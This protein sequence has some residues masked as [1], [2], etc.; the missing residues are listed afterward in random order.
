[1]AFRIT[2]GTPLDAEF[3]R[4]AAEQ[5]DKAFAELS[6]S[7]DR[8][9]AIHDV[10][11]RFKKLRALFRLLRSGDSNLLRAENAR[12]RDAAR[13]LSAVRDRTA[14]LESLEALEQ[15]FADDVATDAF[16]PVRAELERRR[17]AAVEAE[18]DLGETIARTLAT[19]EDSR[20]A[21]GEASF[22]KPLKR[23]PLIVAEG[24][25]HTQRAARR[26]LGEAALN[27]E[28]EAFHDLR[29]HA[30]DHA[31]HLGLLA[32]LWPDAFRVAREVAAGIGDSLG[33]DHDYAILRAEMAGDAG[34][35]GTEADRAVVLGLMDRR[36][37]ALRATSLST[38]RRLFAESPKAAAARI[39][40]L[41]RDAAKA[42]RSPEE[43]ALP[44]E[45][46]LSA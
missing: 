37:G 31:A 42:A 46:G 12:L 5:L 30:K 16:A 35:F 39:E 18:G 17:E 14:L 10:R 44:F 29:K 23:A 41:V 15:H 40:R 22:S 19:I 9:E 25:H 11:K 3:R 33:L 4:I 6:G 27:G 36:Q 45:A 34:A 2:F 7:G 13:A 8:H 28:A 32:D 20:T 43:T 38:A 21:L 24:V 1:M 26:A